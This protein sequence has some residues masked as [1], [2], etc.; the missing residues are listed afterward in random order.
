M[1]AG[2]WTRAA[3]LEVLKRKGR[4]VF[5]KAGRQIALFDTPHGVLACNNRCPH[6]GYPLREG[7]LDGRCILT[8]NWHNWKFDLAKRRETSTAARGCAPIRRRS[9]AGEVWVD[10]ADPPFAERRAEIL[11]SLAE[12]REDNAYEPHGARDRA[13]APARRRRSGCAARRHPLVLRAHGVRLDPRLRG[14]RGL[15]HAARRERG[16]RRD[17]P[18][19]RAGEHRAHRRRRGCASRPVRSPTRPGPGTRRRSWPP[20][21]REDE[22]RRGGDAA[23]RARARGSGSPTSSGVFSRSRARPLQRLRPLADL[24]HQG[25][26]ASSSASAPVSPSRS[27]SRSRAGWCSPP[28]KT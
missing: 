23:R 13:P 4:L 27:S 26:N 11:A 12:A 24:P 25:P 2:T 10:L 17:P 5:R 7:S 1:T 16:R 28:A 6:E 14:R 22:G 15:A 20:S 3:S 18:R 8:C 19:L 21:R 9:A